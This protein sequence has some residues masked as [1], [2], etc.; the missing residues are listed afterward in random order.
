MENTSRSESTG[1]L[2]LQVEDL[3]S[4]ETNYT[5]MGLRTVVR[6]RA[7]L[8][9]ELPSGLHL[10]VFRPWGG[11]ASQGVVARKTRAGGPSA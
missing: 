2:L 9:V 10:M 7:M 8:V 1:R 11:A 4:A 5:R 6:T 3:E